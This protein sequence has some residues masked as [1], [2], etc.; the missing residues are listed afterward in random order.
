MST[1]DYTFVTTCKG[2]LHHLQQTL[3]SLMRTRCTEIIVVDYQCPDHTADWVAAHYPGIKVI[4]VTDDAGFCLPRAR[5][6]G[7]AQVKSPWIVFIDADV[8]V[9]EG[10]DDWLEANVTPGSTY[11][12]GAV[13]GK[14]NPEAFGTFICE[15]AAFE[16]IGGYDE[17]FIGWGGEDIDF[18]RRLAATMRK[19]EYP[20]TLVSAISHGDEERT[21]FTEI[22]N[23][24]LHHIIHE[25]YMQAKSFYAGFMDNGAPLGL[26]DRKRLMQAITTQVL[27]WDG[28]GRPKGSSIQLGHKCAKWLPEPY[29][30]GINATI[31]MAIIDRKE[32]AAGMPARRT[33]ASAASAE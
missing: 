16:R 20:G 29:F 3:P 11:R 13:N 24:Q 8:S 14:I 9:N 1:P 6:I 5:N 27:A 10:W 18:Y 4:R 7:A 21:K 19:G 28:D 33:P 30:M 15:K 12:L 23:I 2:R 32:A 17:S 22:K 25:I 26:E 31:S